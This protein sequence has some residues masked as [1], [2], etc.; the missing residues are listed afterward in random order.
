MQFR[1]G[2]VF[3]GVVITAL[4]FC[5]FDGFSI[6]AAP[7]VGDVHKYRQ[8]GKFDVG[9]T[10]ID[11]SSVSTQKILKVEPSGSYTVKEEVSETKMNGAV[12]PNNQSPQGNTT[13]YS[14]KGEITKIEGDGVDEGVYRFANIALVILPD[15]TVSPGDSWSFDIK[16]DKTKGVMA[17]TA[18][19]TLVGEDKVGAINALKVKFG[20]KEAAAGGGS[21]DGAVWINKVDGSLVKLTAKLINVPVQGGPTIS[22]DMAVT[23]I[24]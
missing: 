15:K 18:K 8:M 10:E 3:A 4:A 5:G 7:K 24:Q 6:K 9:G 12:L 20:V 19:Y 11:F 23:L 16:E 22:G 13:T 14:A 2:A 17:A 21:S 1:S